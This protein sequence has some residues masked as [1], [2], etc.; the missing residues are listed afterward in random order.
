[1]RHGVL[2]EMVEREDHTTD[3]RDLSVQRLALKFG[4]DAQQSQRVGRRRIDGID[5]ILGGRIPL[6]RP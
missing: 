4:V 3:T 2:Y 5:R 1:L 6:L